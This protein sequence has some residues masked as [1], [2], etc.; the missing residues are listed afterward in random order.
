MFNV[1]LMEDVLVDAG[2][3]WSRGRILG[4]LRQRPPRLV[5]LTHCHPDHQGVARIVCRQFK[6]PL[7]CHELDVA[8]V[9]GR[10]PMTPDSWMMRLGMRCWGGP[11]APV[12]RVLHDGDEVA[13]FRVVHTPGHTPGHV[14]FFRDADR[15]AVAGDVLVNIHFLTLQPGLRMPPPFF[16]DDAAQNRESIRKL[17]ALQPSVVC[18][19]HGP[20]LYQTE[21]LDKLVERLDARARTAASAY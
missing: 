8:A 2:T 6:V 14:V 12:T 7:A 11:P 5:A 21:L 17:A 19:G 4:Q 9:E 16:C 13:G 3:R 10:A 20:P 15:V 18:F 1:Y